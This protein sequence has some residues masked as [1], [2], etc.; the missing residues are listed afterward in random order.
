MTGRH[1]GELMGIPPTGTQIAL[2]G[3]TIMHF[4]GGRVIERF[5]QA[6]MLG[7]LVQLGAVP[8]PA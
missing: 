5:S 8:A 4:D 6:D 3:I 2:P 1:V 7:L